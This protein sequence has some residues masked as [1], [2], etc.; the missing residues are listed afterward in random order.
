MSVNP[1]IETISDPRFRE[2]CEVAASEM[3]RLAI[4]GVVVG[5]LHEGQEWA[6]GLGVTS[7]ENPLP[8]TSDTLYQIGSITKT[9]LATLVM[10]LVEMGILDLAAPVRTYLPELKLKDESV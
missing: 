2:L 9:Y 7:V 1:P 3:Q 10:R 4:P 8:V 6:A 5:V